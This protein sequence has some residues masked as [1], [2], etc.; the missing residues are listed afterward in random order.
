[1]VT[2]F[3]KYRRGYSKLRSTRSGN[4][5]PWFSI[6]F[7]SS[8]WNTIQGR[9][10]FSAIRG[11]WHRELGYHDEMLKRKIE[12]MKLLEGAPGVTHLAL[13]IDTD[14]LKPDPPF[15]PHGCGWEWFDGQQ[16]PG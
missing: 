11:Y 15:N 5:F 7:L 4:L 13:D 1:M 16:D 9:T 6:A 8:T 2:L 10:G 3:V 12:F 14:A